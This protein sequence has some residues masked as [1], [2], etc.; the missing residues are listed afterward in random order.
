MHQEVD[1]EKQGVRVLGV[2]S[3]SVQFSPSVDEFTID[4]KQPG[5]R[6][7]ELLANGQIKTKVH[8]VADNKFNPV[9]D[10]VGY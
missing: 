7:L 5:F 2:P 4:E 1:V 6:F 9:F 3:T 10:P 8:R